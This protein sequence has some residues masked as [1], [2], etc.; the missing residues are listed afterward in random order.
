[1]VELE[2]KNFLVFIYVFLSYYLSSVFLECAVY[3]VARR[4]P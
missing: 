3:S 2:M 1:M 4:I